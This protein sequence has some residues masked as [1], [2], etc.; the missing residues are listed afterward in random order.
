M[1]CF[2][3]T[4]WKLAGNSKTLTLPQLSLIFIKE[5]QY[6]NLSWFPCN[7]TMS[8]LKQSYFLSLGLLRLEISP[9][10][11]TVSCCLTPEMLPVRPFPE[12]RTRPHKEI[13]EFPVREVYVPHTVYRWETKALGKPLNPH[14]EF[15][16]GNA[17]IILQRIFL[18]LWENEIRCLH[19]Y[20]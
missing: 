3:S 11:E 4:Y 15:R 19:T 12:N 17:F 5:I 2:F 9:A 18:R 1:T 14:L 20:R 13:L 6:N 16:L 7:M 10:P 8:L